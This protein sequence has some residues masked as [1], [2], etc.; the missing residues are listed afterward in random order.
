MRWSGERAIAG[1]GGAIAF[2]IMPVSSL[3]HRRKMAAKYTYHNTVK[4]ALIK[5]G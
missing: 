2:A 5:E 1:S 4:N 3:T